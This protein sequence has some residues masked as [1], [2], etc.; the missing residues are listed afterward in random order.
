MSPIS[1]DA[2]FSMHRPQNL[3]NYSSCINKLESVF[4]PLI[5]G[6]NLFYNVLLVFTPGCTQKVVKCYRDDPYTSMSYIGKLAQVNS[7][8]KNIAW[9]KIR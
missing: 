2:L 9:S 8:N 6:K 5:D 1:L 4:Y 7:V 3:F